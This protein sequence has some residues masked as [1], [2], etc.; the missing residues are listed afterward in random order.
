MCTND[1]CC[2]RIS[3]AGSH[4]Q[5]GGP[6]PTVAS[7]KLFGA[8]QATNDT[9][10]IAA[11]QLHTS[12]AKD[13][14]KSH[15]SWGVSPQRKRPRGQGRPGRWNLWKRNSWTVKILIRKFPRLPLPA[16]RTFFLCVGGSAQ[17]CMLPH[18]GRQPYNDRQGP[19]VGWS[20]VRA[21]ILVLLSTII[22]YAGSFTTT[23]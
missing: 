13:A 9:L 10:P 23:G 22:R 4:R 15:E 2:E 5:A 14:Q 18:L 3:N 21:E 1:S 7:Y 17:R 19:L 16:F 20:V 6:G 12:T 11:F 8:F